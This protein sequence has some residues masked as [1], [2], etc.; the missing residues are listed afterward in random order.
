MKRAS[1]QN[2]AWA[3][4]LALGLFVFLTSGRCVASIDS[5][6]D[7]FTELS[8]GP[9]YPPPTSVQ[10]KVSSA[11]EPGMPLDMISMRVN[12]VM[13]DPTL[14]TRMVGS[15]SGGGVG[16]P[17]LNSFFDVYLMTD[18]FQSSFFDIFTE[19]SMM[20]GGP[21]PV[22]GTPTVVWHTSSFFDVF[23]EVD[24]PGVDR[25][26]ITMQV[27]IPDGQ[28]V[29]FASPEAVTDGV[30]VHTTFMVSKTG[31]PPA[32]LTLPLFRIVVTGTWGF[33][34]PTPT[35]NINKFIQNPDRSA[36]GLDVLAGPNTNAD[37]TATMLADDFI[38]TQTGPIS[39]IHIWGSW[40]NDKLDRRPT[41]WL[42]IWSDVPATK[43]SP[44]RPGELLWSQVFPPGQYQGSLYKTVP[45]E[46]FYTRHPTNT[47]MGADHQ[48]WKYDFFPRTSFRQTGTPWLPKIYWLSLVASNMPGTY[49]GWK[50]TPDHFNDAASFVPVQI[51]PHFPILTDSWRVLTDITRRPRELSFAITTSQQRQWACNKDFYRPLP[52]ANVRV[53]MPWRWPISGH[54][55]GGGIFPLFGEFAWAWNASDNTVLDWTG[56]AS[57][58]YEVVHVGFEGPG[59]FP[60]F[61]NWGWWDPFSM[62][63]LGW[64]PQVNI[65]WPPAFP[66]LIPPVI[67]I[68]NIVTDRAITNSVFISN[69]SIEYF[70]NAVE[71]TQ[72]NRTGVRNPIRTDVA[73][74]A[75]P[76]IPPGGFTT[77]EIP[78][79]PV[80]ATFAVVIPQISP[81]NVDGL[82]MPAM[83]STDYAMYPMTALVPNPPPPEPVIQTPVMTETEVML[84]WTAQPGAIYRVQSKATVTSETSWE[85]VEGDV[86]AGEATA[87][88]AVPLGG[89][90]RFYRVF[91]FAP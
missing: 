78:I 75:A 86:I 81:V 20:A 59:S 64:I 65:G 56:M 76:M 61:L 55:D 9:P 50:T 43:D 87:S 11:M 72:L 22:V 88:K 52:F 51:K 35:F 28:P 15:D 3:V 38:C 62:N 68:T 25:Q 82:P 66:P 21:L 83:A 85:D 42:G 33:P 90:T 41:F 6:F 47:I 46:T 79:P 40:L 77:V 57:G 45:F 74:P 37:G 1:I 26:F 63:W 60:P 18:G 70:T 39:D 23:L 80:E 36:Y 84:T 12:S 32:I 14:G 34:N 31:V 2:G 89:T 91:G 24:V 71:L 54:F 58:Q 16:S 13:P 10:A 73:M 53:V 69:L 67:G 49:F 17:G 44:S 27:R 7:I 8:V 5:F 30:G 4:V 48:I 19:I 29:Q